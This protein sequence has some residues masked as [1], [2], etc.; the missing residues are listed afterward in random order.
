ML[1][2]LENNKRQ[3]ITENDEVEPIQLTEKP[4]DLF[5]RILD[6]IDRYSYLWDD[7]FAGPITKKELLSHITGFQSLAKVDSET[8]S[9]K[10]KIKLK[11]IPKAPLTIPVAPKFQTEARLSIKDKQSLKTSEELEMEEINK[12]KAL[13]ESQIKMNQDTV[14]QLDSYEK[15]VFQK[16]ESTVFKEFNFQTS[17][18]S[19]KHSEFRKKNIEKL[20]EKR[21]VEKSLMEDK[22]QEEKNNQEKKIKFYNS[23]G[24]NLHKPDE[25][26]ENIGQFVSLKSKIE[27]VL[28]RKEDEDVKFEQS[29]KAKVVKRHL[30]TPKSPELS[31]KKRWEFSEKIKA[32]KTT[33]ELEL[34]KMTHSAFKARPIPKSIFSA[35]KD[36]LKRTPTEKKTEIQEFNITQVRKKNILTTEEIELQTHCKDFKAT[37]LDKK[38]FENTLESILGKEKRSLCHSSSWV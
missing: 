1:K 24:Q 38:I 2:V 12:K 16:K 6:N 3:K 20:E 29:P 31:V 37:E 5:Q 28:M 11:K 34:E 17:E 4:A 15:P 26:N 8:D 13:I 30:T 19:S 36:P 33:E 21:E 7:T 35:Q 9:N 27:G 14:K 32:L 18:R 10:N 22:K 23:W 25:N